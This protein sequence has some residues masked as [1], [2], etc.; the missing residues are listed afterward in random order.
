MARDTRGSD[1]NSWRGNRAAYRTE[2]LWQASLWR[3]AAARFRQTAG[4]ARPGGISIPPDA[5]LAAVTA[6][7]DSAIQSMQTISAQIAALSG[8]RAN[9]EAR[10]ASEEG[11]I[12]RACVERVHN[13][14]QEENRR[15]RERRVQAAKG[16]VLVR[17]GL[18]VAVFA[19]TAYLLIY[20]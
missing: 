7:G 4:D 6:T 19:V 12:Q 3:T 5:P 17:K 14:R 9:A 18:A 15:K 1:L 10:L 13:E 2:V 16:A 20:H 8:E 11:E